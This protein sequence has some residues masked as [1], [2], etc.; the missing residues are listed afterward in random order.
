[1]GNTKTQFK[2]VLMLLLTAIIWGVSF[3]AQSVGTD[4]LGGFSFNGIRTLIGAV[5]LLPFVIYGSV[6]KKKG[7]SLSELKEYKKT[8]RKEFKIG[9]FIGV[10]FCI[11]CNAQQYAFVYGCSSGKVAFITAMY[12][13]IVP[14]I[15]MISGKR[16]P[17]LTIVSVIIGIAG[18]YFLCI[19]PSDLSTFGLGEVFALVCAVFYA[20]HIV[21]IEKYAAE[22]DDIKLSFTQFAFSGIVTS[23]L[24]L[25]FENPTLEG[26]KLSVIPL[27]Y[28][29]V[30]SCGVA[31]TLQIVGQK[32]T[33]ATVAS[34]LMCLE[35]VFAAIAG[36][37]L[38]KEYMS[39][40]EIIGACIMFS[41]II[42]SQIAQNPKFNK[43]TEVTSLN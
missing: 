27:L 34:I 36:A 12:M 14:I 2:G 29:G 15:K 30:L 41:A 39:I 13:F 28:S 32:Y 22:C 20:L 43:K 35:S 11:A 24:M 18:M 19:N 38:L 42:L 31:Y 6:K 10:I 7:L 23:V 9:I 26:I 16:I 17:A 21:F 25:V 37:L 40:R 33:E 4:I 3:V 8:S 1:M 5:V